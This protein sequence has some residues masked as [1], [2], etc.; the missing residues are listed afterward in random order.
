M[1][2]WQT[3]PHELRDGVGQ[4]ITVAREIL[5]SAGHATRSHDGRSIEGP[6]ALLHESLGGDPHRLGSRRVR[7]QV[8]ERE[9]IDAAFLV[10]PVVRRDVGRRRRRRV[11]LDANQVEGRDR[12]RSAVDE[13]FEFVGRHVR[14]EVALTIDNPRIQHDKRRLTPK[15]RGRLAR[16]RR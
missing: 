5:T 10:T 1:R 12:L 9:D 14:H 15:R 16:L 8:V 7:L 11:R 2:L 4:S 13:H 6:D 3:L